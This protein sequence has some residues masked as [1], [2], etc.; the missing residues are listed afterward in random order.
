MWLER[1]RKGEEER[2]GSEPQESLEHRSLSFYILI[3]VQADVGLVR[4]ERPTGLNPGARGAG[5]SK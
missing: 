1:G 5:K 4:L 3:S 2:K